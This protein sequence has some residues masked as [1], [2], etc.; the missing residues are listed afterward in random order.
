M[1]IKDVVG[2]VV[3]ECVLNHSCTVSRNSLTPVASA[4]SPRAP[5]ALSKRSVKLFST[6]S[7][8]N[9]S[10]SKSPVS[11]PVNT[12][13]PVAEPIAVAAHAGIPVDAKT[14]PKS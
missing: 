13:F 3:N 10:G 9:S 11:A 14:G 2:S 6:T 1:S 4:T 8:K 12:A 7:F 5:N